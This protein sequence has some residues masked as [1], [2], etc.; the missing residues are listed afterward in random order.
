MCQH[1]DG[2]YFQLNN[3]YNYL[4]INILS[5]LLLSLISL[6]T[7]STGNKDVPQIPFTIFLK[8]SCLKPFNLLQDLLNGKTWKQPPVILWKQW[9]K[10]KNVVISK[11]WTCHEID[12]FGLSSMSSGGVTTCSSILAALSSVRLTKY[13]NKFNRPWIREVLYSL[14]NK[15]LDPWIVLLKKFWIRRNGRKLIKYREITLRRIIKMRSC[16][17]KRFWAIYC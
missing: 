14:S 12:K 3:F 2:Y 5:L 16:T 13:A 1:S 7:L 8:P 11:S 4:G 10:L 15:L 9:Y 17:I 6:H